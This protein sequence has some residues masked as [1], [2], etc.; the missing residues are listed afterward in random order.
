MLARLSSRSCRVLPGAC[1]FVF[2]ALASSAQTSV[3]DIVRQASA[4]LEEYREYFRQTG[5]V[6]GRAPILQQV[7]AVLDR[8]CAAAAAGD[9]AGAAAC[10]VKAGDA[11]RML[12]QQFISTQMSTADQRAA[13]TMMGE[14]LRRYREGE[15]LARATSAAQPLAEALIGE[16]RTQ[17]GVAAQHDYRAAAAS[18]EE[19]IG[20]A[21]TLPDRRTLADALL[22]KSELDAEQGDLLAA[23]DEVNRVLAIQQK[24][25]DEAGRF[26]ALLDRAS[27]FVEMASWCDYKLTFGECDDNA[28]RAHADYEAGRAIAAARKWPGL[29][30]ML[31][32]EIGGIE[33]R[34]QLIAGR[35]RSQDDVAKLF[36]PKV[37]GDVTVSQIYVTQS[38]TPAALL[39]LLKKAGALP[40]NPSANGTYLKAIEADTRGDSDAAI[41]LYLNAVSI[42]EGDRRQASDS[43]ARGQFLESKIDIYYP[44]MLQLL[45]KGRV[46]EAFRLVEAS[47]S[48]V[49]ADLMATHQQA[50]DAPQR[51][52][53]ARDQAFRAS[54]DRAQKELFDARTSTDYAPQE[55]ASAE[56]RLAQLERDRAGVAAEI[57]KTAPALLEPTFREPVPLAEV[58][59]AADAGAYDVLEYVVLDYAVIVWHIGSGGVHVRN[60]FLPRAE[61]AAK[62]DRLRE[63][64]AHG[65]DVPFDATTA[66]E[67]FL[68]LIEPMRPFIKSGHLVIVPHEELHYAPFQAFQDPANGRFVAQAFGLSY[69]PSATILNNLKPG[70]DLSSST[71]LAVAGPDLA[72]AEGEVQAIVR[73]YPSGR[74]HALLNGSATKQ[75]VERRAAASDVVHLAAHGTFDQLEP[76]LSYVTLAPPATGGDGHLTAAE[77]Y[78]LPLARARLVTL[79]ACQ[80]GRAT[81]TH[82]GDVVGMQRALIYAGAG[83]LLL[84]QWEVD[85]TSTAAWMAAFYREAAH[86]PVVGA[87]QRATEALLATAEFRHPYFWAPFF[88]VGR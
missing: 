7:L 69:A 86:V 40:A 41:A 1:A 25:G 70:G 66:R 68:F 67:L 81:A 63:S 19:A 64:V 74:V 88:V 12:S 72:Q 21:A 38:G 55:I 73:A 35:K 47:R 17:L 3:S 36:H 71:I 39:G 50:V 43:E 24:R 80:T 31:N 53:L 20:V 18:V 76:L 16:V 34:R 87:A 29:V 54:I 61:L 49:L 83:A 26:Y 11:E 75:E 51:A 9:A 14:A 10:F 62:V 28:M 6:K 5:D 82:G 22:E 46:A 42:L 48:R 44:P 77:M 52:L 59:R 32:D 79:S 15:R 33:M 45:Q 57:R 8:A 84:T 4:R 27:D 85:S 56:Q 13:V 30:K 78:G 23:V 65:K 60:V 2:S 58:L 37:A